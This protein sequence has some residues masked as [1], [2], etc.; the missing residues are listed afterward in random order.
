MN[1]I[2]GKEMNE[3]YKAAIKLIEYLEKLNNYKAAEIVW[4]LIC[5][6]TEVGTTSEQDK[7]LREKDLEI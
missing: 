4:A 2:S 7:L 3:A 5:Q 1:S 6:N